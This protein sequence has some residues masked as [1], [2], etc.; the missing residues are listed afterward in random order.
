MKKEARGMHHDKKGAQTNIKNPSTG[1][2][3][4]KELQKT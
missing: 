3:V 2:Y 1:Y 4:L